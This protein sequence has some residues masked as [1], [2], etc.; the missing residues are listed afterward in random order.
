V[1]LHHGILEQSNVLL[2]VHLV[3]QPRLRL[4]AVS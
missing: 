4:V 2:R 1:S 3:F